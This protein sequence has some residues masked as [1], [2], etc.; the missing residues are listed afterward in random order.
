[1]SATGP[2]DDFNRQIIG[3]FRANRGRVGGPFNGAPLLLLHSTGARS[4]TVRVNPVMYQVLAD[5]R[6][7]VFA[8]NG[9]ADTNPA[10]YRNVTAHSDVTAELPIG[11]DVELRRY[12]ARIAVGNERDRIWS[13]QKALNPGFAAY[14]AA[15][16]RL[17]PVIVLEPNPD[18][19]AV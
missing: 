1:M 17:I 16:D 14:E 15:T 9:G 4:G 13:N 19:A 7:A 8:S 5:G 6:L 3:E 11:D 18:G 2:Q 12:R 10:W